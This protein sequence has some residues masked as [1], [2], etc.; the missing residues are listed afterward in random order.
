MTGPGEPRASVP[1]RLSVVTLGASDLASLRRFY[2]DLGWAEVAGSDD[3]WSAFVLG[4]VVLALFPEADLAAESSMPAERGGFTLA[5]NVDGRDDVDAGCA[6]MVAAGASVVAAP[7]DRS[8]GGRSGYVAD[9]EGN[10]WEIAW[11]PSMVFGPAGEVRTF[12]G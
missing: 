1:P 12:G 5:L 3:S 4:G 6:A 8:W 11:T 10:R 7:Q 9:P 2:R